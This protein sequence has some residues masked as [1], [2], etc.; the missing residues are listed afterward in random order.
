MKTLNV[1]AIIYT[2]IPSFLND[3][4]FCRDALYYCIVSFGAP[5]MVP[6]VLSSSIDSFGDPT[7]RCVKGYSGYLS[8]YQQPPQNQQAQIYLN[9]LLYAVGQGNPANINFS[10]KQKFQ[11]SGLQ[12]IYPAAYPDNGKTA[13]RNFEGFPTRQLIGGGWLNV[14]NHGKLA[15]IM[16]GT[17]T[18]RSSNAADY[19]TIMAEK[20]ALEDLLFAMT[21]ITFKTQPAE[22]NF[23]EIY[24]STDPAKMPDNTI[25]YNYLHDTPT[26]EHFDPSEIQGL[27]AAGITAY[28]VD[29][30][31]ASSWS[32]LFNSPMGMDFLNAVSRILPARGQETLA[33]PPGSTQY[34]EQSGAHYLVYQYWV[35]EFQI[36]AYPGNKII[37]T[38]DYERKAGNDFLYHDKSFL[39]EFGPLLAAVAVVAAM[40]LLAPPAALAPTVA[41]TQGASSAV[42]GGA[43]AAYTP[44]AL[45]GAAP[46]LGTFT[47]V[48]PLAGTVGASGSL[49][50][51]GGGSGILGAVDT[52]LG[53]GKAV[54][55]FVSTGIGV[56]QAL[57]SM[58][59]AQP[60]VTE[61][62]KSFMGMSLELLLI[63]AG[64]LA[65]V[66]L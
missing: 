18:K 6:N 3:Y 34:M 12:N 63:G 58:E 16:D 29:W 25:S 5:I 41:G 44:E 64:V 23:D 57:K 43:A 31:K 26:P 46:S 53:A 21:D 28:Q 14:D 37:V 48:D 42:A 51:A 40:A 33:T 50:A 9:T 62:T 66:L 8:V 47:V 7:N 4:P 60:A 36:A 65:M 22:Q 32:A 27:Q 54:A 55:G 61:P 38:Y 35:N 49:G 56:E 10:L 45:A 17:M 1:P 20:N 15:K 52:V 24:G 13:A 2:D 59:S 11:P 30:S 19:D 39:A